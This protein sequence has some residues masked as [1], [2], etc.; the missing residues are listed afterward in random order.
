MT[1]S[2]I[3]ENVNSDLN[4]LCRQTCTD[5]EGWPEDLDSLHA[6]GTNE[7][8]FSAYPCWEDMLRP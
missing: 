7:Y 8:F 4:L 2:F 3:P 5:P 1:K 6:E